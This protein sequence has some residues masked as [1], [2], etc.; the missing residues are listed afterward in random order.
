[1]VGRRPG[2]PTL[3]GLA[4]GRSVGRVLPTPS[5]RRAARGGGSVGRAMPSRKP[6]RPSGR[7]GRSGTSREREVNNQL[8][9]AIYFEPNNQPPSNILSF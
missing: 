9:T 1:M 4:Q 2:P 3:L 6:L 7:V 8:R 5:L